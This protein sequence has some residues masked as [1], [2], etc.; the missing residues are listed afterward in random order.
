MS[1]MIIYLFQLVAPLY[2]TL[3]SGSLIKSGSRIKVN[4]KSGLLLRIGTLTWLM[5]I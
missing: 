4:V 3:E 5:C 1:K 2:V